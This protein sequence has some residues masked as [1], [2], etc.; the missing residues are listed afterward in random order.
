MAGCSVADITL[1]IAEATASGKS[2]HD[3]DEQ[4]RQIDDVTYTSNMTIT[5]EDAQSKLPQLLD[6]L[7]PGEELVLQ[8]EGKPVAKLV[9]LQSET[10]GKSLLGFAKGEFI[11]PDDFDEPL[12]KDIEDT[13]YE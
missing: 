10:E 2:C 11:V 4:R 5:V 3:H 8:R 13:F 9:R 6:E 1:M 7:A 12:P